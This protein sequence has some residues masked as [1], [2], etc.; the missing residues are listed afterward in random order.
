MRQRI[1]L[2]LVGSLLLAGLAIVVWHGI[3]PLADS[4]VYF[5]RQSRSFGELGIILLVG[6]TYYA[7]LALVFGLMRRY[8]P[9]V[10]AI[11]I[12][13]FGGWWLIIV[14]AALSVFNPIFLDVLGIPMD[15]GGA[16]FIFITL[17]VG[18]AK[19]W[20]WAVL[21]DRPFFGGPTPRSAVPPPKKDPE[22]TG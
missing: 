1:R 12:A 18:A 8:D 11:R 2:E 21:E 15:G 9:E 16:A 3:M 19:Q 6:A 14:L 22:R 10:N 13:Y 17:F 5:L 7:P 20:R 4:I